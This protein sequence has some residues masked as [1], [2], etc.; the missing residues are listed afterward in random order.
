MIDKERQNEILYY[1]EQRY[2]HYCDGTELI[3]DDHEDLDF[4]ILFYL[5]EHGLIEAPRLGRTAVGSFII[6]RVIITSKGLDYLSDDGGL[7]TDLQLKFNN[8]TVQINGDSREFLLELLESPEIPQEQ[9]NKFKGIIDL[10]TE[11]G[12]K[13]ISRSIITDAIS[14]IPEHI[15]KTP[16]YLENI[17]QSLLSS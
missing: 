11:E 15:A 6:S 9:K 4:A 3:R 2:P 14:N 1:L 16:F 7:S 5:Q 12:L 10:M 17:I 8:V 13:T